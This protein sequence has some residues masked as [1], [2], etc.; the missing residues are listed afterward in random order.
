MK[1]TLSTAA[2]SAVLAIGM[3]VPA[4]A[5]DNM[6]G[7]SVMSAGAAKITL[8]GNIRERGAM[9]QDSAVKNTPNQSYYDGRIRLGV[10]AQVTDQVT[11]YIQMESMSG[12]DRNYTWGDGSAAGLH[13]GGWKNTDTTMAAREAW[14]NYNPG[15]WGVKVGH[16]PLA[17]G[18][19]LFFDHE[20]FGD[21]AIL[22]YTSVAGTNLAGILIKFDEQNL[23][24]STDDLDG[25]VL[26]ATHKFGDNLDGGINWTYLQGGSK[27][28]GELAQGMSFSNV[29]VNANYKQDNL[30]FLA[31]VEGQFGTLSD[32]GVTSVDGKGFA[33]K[34][35]ANADLGSAKVGL[36]YGYGSGDNGNTGDNDTFQNFLDHTNYDTLIVGY[37]AATPGIGYNNSGLANLS[38]YQLNVS[39]KTTC[40]MTGKDLSLFASATY[41]QLNK[42]LNTYGTNMED[43]VGTELDGIATW[44]L[45]PGL[46]YK[47][48]LGYLFAGSAWDQSTAGSDDL[49]FV[50]HGLELSF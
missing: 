19:K 6:M 13:E 29:G 27:G 28:S 30:S 38:E 25:Y 24:D 9:E 47:V 2:L 10:K 12:A 39:T 48:E 7:S 32:N 5:A 16:M 31:D 14:I 3:A 4:M 15:S 46:D 50:R 8:D 1:K 35:G 49:Y 22:A 36:I 37:R 45:A 11:G 40:P 20:S 33:F 41:M 17:L 43:N 42:S 44:N 26:L 34:L 21:D 18:N 23:N